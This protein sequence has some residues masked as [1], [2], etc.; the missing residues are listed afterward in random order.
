MY[1]AVGNVMPRSPNRLPDPPP[2][3]EHPKDGCFAHQTG[4][5]VKNSDGRIIGRKGEWVKKTRHTMMSGG[6]KLAGASSSSK[7]QIFVRTQ[8]DTDR[9]LD[10]RPVVVV[11][12]VNP[13]AAP[14]RR[15][16]EH[17]R[18]LVRSA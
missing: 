3:R 11:A 2:N 18:R 12:Q 10:A 5:T 8:V 4:Q 17:R 14:A 16:V 7:T 1:D 13:G 6:S 15:H 9:R